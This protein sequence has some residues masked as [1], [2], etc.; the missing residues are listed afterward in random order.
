MTENAGEGQQDE[1]Q[2]M[3]FDLDGG[4]KSEW[5]GMPEFVQQDLEPFKSVIVH[6]S[7]QGDVELFS[8]V[9][10]QT[11]GPRTRSIWYPEAEIGHMMNKRYA[12]DGSRS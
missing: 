6:F 3:L 12:D 11:V 4:W 1:E 2:P 10:E 5:K 9:V 8:K 7:S